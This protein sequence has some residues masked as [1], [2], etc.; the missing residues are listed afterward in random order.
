MIRPGVRKTERGGD[1]GK[2]VRAGT[3]QL[4]TDPINPWACC[5]VYDPV[6]VNLRPILQTVCLRTFHYFAGK[7]WLNATPT[8]LKEAAL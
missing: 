3:V 1:G 8:R 4:I 2:Q 6:T 7:W 5:P